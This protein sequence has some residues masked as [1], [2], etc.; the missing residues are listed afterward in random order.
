MQH[1]TH[2]N[3]AFKFIYQQQSIATM[4]KQ[5]SQ[6][7]TPPPL[8]L[9]DCLVDSQIDLIRYRLYARRVYDNKYSDSLIF[10]TKKR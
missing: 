2:N 7:C 3:H 10:N 6:A 8:T 9:C 4:G 1:I 5:I